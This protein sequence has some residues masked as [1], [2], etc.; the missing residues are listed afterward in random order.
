MRQA[1]T[2]GEPGI[3]KPTLVEKFLQEER[4]ATG[5]SLWI[6]RGQC[7]EHYGAGE[8]YLP[9][10]DALGRLCRQPQGVRMVELLDKHAPAWLIQMPLLLGTIERNALQGGVAGAT[11][12]RMLRELADAIE[13]ISEERP[14]VLWAS[15]GATIRYPRPTPL[16]C[17]ALASQNAVRCGRQQG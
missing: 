5:E 11:R 8:A 12:E 4:V 1:P 3:G 2:T 7:I 17:R 14:V 6:G 16:G 13:V 10:L 9:L 15:I